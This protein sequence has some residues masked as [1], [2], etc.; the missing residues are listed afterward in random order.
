[1]VGAGPWTALVNPIVL[2]AAL[3]PRTGGLLRVAV[4]QRGA[5]SYSR[6]LLD[7]FTRE[8]QAQH[9]DVPVYDRETQDVRFCLH[10][11][12]HVL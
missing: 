2:M 5:Q 6:K 3:A 8:F 4:S 12:R 11:S 9:P 10:R 7:D 1:M